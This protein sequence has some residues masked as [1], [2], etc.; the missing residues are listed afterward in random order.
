MSTMLN[1]SRALNHMFVKWRMS[2]KIY[3]VQ[4]IR[5]SYSAGFHLSSWRTSVA[6]LL[7][8]LRLLSI[9][10]NG[11]TNSEGNSSPFRALIRVIVVIRESFAPSVSQL[12]G[13]AIRGTRPPEF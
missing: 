11:L 3:Y 5:A 9:A 8:T 7:I 1:D 13:T 10:G 12:D 6:L 2:Y 4:P